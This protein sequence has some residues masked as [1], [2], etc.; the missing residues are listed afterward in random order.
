MMNTKRMLLKAAMS[1]VALHPVLVSAV[2]PLTPGPR[3]DYF[4]NAI[5]QTHEGKNVRFYDDVVKGDK[6]VVINMMYTICTDI[7]PPNTANLMRVQEMLGDR[8]CRDIFMYSLTLQPEID[9]PEVLRAYVKLY[10]IKPGWT[11]LT[12]KR[13][14][15]ELIRRKLGFFD[16]DAERDAK[17]SEHTGMVRMGRE[18]FDRWTMMPGLAKPKQ[19]VNSILRF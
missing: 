13:N 15:I 6:V 14:D 5:L 19:L 8:I 4:P 1:S 17:L 3:A 16:R 12:G 11:F 10:G 18:A 2:K 7:C 9:T